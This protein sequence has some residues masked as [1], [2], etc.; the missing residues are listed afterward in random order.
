MDKIA[1]ILACALLTIALTLAF[2]MFFEPERAL[3]FGSLITWLIAVGKELYDKYVKK[4]TFDRMD[5]VADLIGI[6]GGVAYMLI[7]INS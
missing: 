6:F 3:S 7:I 1:H 4:T 5:I 2:C